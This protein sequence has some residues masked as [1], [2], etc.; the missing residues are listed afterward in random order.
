ML[1][2]LR[3]KLEHGSAPGTCAPIIET[4]FVVSVM[5]SV[6]AFQREIGACK[7]RDKSKWSQH[8]PIGCTLKCTLPAQ[9]FKQAIVG[10]T[11]EVTGMQVRIPQRN[12][13]G[14]LR[15]NME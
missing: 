8:L 15:R 6:G 4:E 7:N 5:E 13:L 10:E 2:S 14:S 9:L 11:D 3:A 12:L 1:W